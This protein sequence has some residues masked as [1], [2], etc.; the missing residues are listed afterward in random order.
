[1]ASLEVGHVYIIRTSLTKPL[2]KDKFTVCVSVSD[3][4]FIWFNTK[5]Q[6]HGQGQL[7]C[8][9]HDHKA[10]T[11]ECFLDLSR[12]TRFGADEIDTA[13]HR[14]ALSRSLCERALAMLDEGIQTLPPRHARIIREALLSI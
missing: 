13:R 4:F 2:P 8:D 10:L 6:H 7:R 5:P 1:M 9:E 14:G 11:R 3:G 12:L